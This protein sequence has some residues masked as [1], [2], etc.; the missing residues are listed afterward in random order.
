[1][2]LDAA[3]DW[4]VRQDG[5]DANGGGWKRTAGTTD[6]SLFAAA[7]L[8]ATDL[9][10]AS[11]TTLTSATGGFTAAMV[12]NVVQIA[13]GTN[14]LAGFYE[15]TAYAS[16]N[17]VT[18]DRTCATGGNM[19]AG[20]GKVGGALASL[21]AAA[22]VPYVA[23]NQFYVKYSATPY[24]C[25]GAAT[26]SV[27]GSYGTHTFIHGY[28][29]TRSIYNTDANRPTIR[30][31]DS[32]VTSITMLVLNG[33][34]LV[35]AGLILDGNGKTE[36]QGI[37]HSGAWV[38]ITRCKVLNCTNG[39]IVSTYPVINCEADTCSIGISGGHIFGCYA[40]DC[41]SHGFYNVTTIVDCL[42]V[43]NGGIGIST[44][45]SAFIVNRCIAYGNAGN[46]FA[47][48]GLNHLPVYNCIAEGN[49]GWGFTYQGYTSP[50]LFYCA[51]YNTS[52]S[53][54]TSVVKSQG[55]VEV[56]NGSVFTNAAAGDFTLNN[57][58]LRGA[59][60]RGVGF[61]GTFLNGNVGYA[62]IGLFQH[63]DAGGGGAIV[64]QGLHAIEAGISA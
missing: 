33:T 18:I 27:A 37:S 10:C 55:C 26:F 7:E 50:R 61:P 25:L 48:S 17:S 46:G 22:S 6:Y 23:G 36:I 57:T 40:H 54:S 44:G 59:L 60:L 45:N 32:G 38:A 5:N 24:V 3:I 42:S 51:T 41:T 4:E 43:G 56:T 28:D 21:A 11:N 49:G 52:G 8:S 9:A 34:N 62:D 58:A 16:T 35:A 12:G 47:V 64:N 53:F 14:A 63:E 39:G 13:S 2:A 19:T 29:T 31:A 15:I 30:V 20:V 1:M